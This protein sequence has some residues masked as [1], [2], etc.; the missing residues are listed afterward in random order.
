MK[1]ENMPY[2]CGLCVRHLD[3]LEDAD[4]N[5]AAVSLLMMI[6]TKARYIPPCLANYPV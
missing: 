4:A 6:I 2:Y 5:V 1:P 3:D